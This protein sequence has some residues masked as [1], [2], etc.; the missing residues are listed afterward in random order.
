MN[1]LPTLIHGAQ[2]MADFLGFSLRK[3]ERFIAEELADRL[4]DVPHERRRHRLPI[5]KI[6]GVWCG[7][8]ED[9]AAWLH[10][11]LYENAA[12]DGPRHGA[13]DHN[14]CA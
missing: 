7:R 11:R 14:D 10:E 13:Y 9:L 3:M 12:P 4:E 8:P 5:A 1:R 6:G 2:A